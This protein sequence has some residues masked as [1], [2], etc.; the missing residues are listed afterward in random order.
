M[1]RRFVC[2]ALLAAWSAASAAG[3]ILVYGDSLSAAYGIG[4]KEGWASLLEERLRQRKLDYTVANASI[5]GETTSGGA[6]RID[7]A[8]ERFKPEVVIVALG[9]NDGLRGL[10]IAEMKANLDRI[11]N[12]SRAR[13][14]RVLVVGMRMPPNYGTKYTQAFHEAFADVAR[15]HRAAYVPFLLEGVADK[16]DLFLPDQIHPSAQAQ[17]ILLDTVWRGLEPLLGKR[18]TGQ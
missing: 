12:A 7:A 2:F 16:R 6:A 9:A 4:Q 13:R 5:S 3:T 18:R 10:P 14:A 17:P 15:Q 11:A 8:L 1:F